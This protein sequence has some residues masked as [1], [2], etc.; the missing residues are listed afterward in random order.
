[1][2]FPLICRGLRARPGRACGAACIL[3]TGTPAAPR[4]HCPG[5]P[6]CGPRCGYPGGQPPFPGDNTRLLVDFMDNTKNLEITGQKA[7]RQF[8]GRSRNS[9]IAKAEVL[10]GG[11]SRDAGETR[12]TGKPGNRHFSCCFPCQA[13]GR[14][15]PG[16]RATGS[17]GPPRPGGAPP[18][19]TRR[20]PIRISPTRPR[21]G[22]DLVIGCPGQ[23]GT[24]RDQPA[25][26]GH[27]PLAS[28][29]LVPPV[30]LA[31][32]VHVSRGACAGSGKTPRK[33][34]LFAGNV[35][36]GHDQSDP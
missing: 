25:A 18:T 6:I 7:L 17:P 30:T 3:V 1:M 2:A 19:H 14:T 26:P 34:A 33:T 15:G 5:E 22:A 28:P 8:S 11:N 4:T 20:G 29:G 16:C 24:T 35:A 12:A 10:P 23:R 13:V 27:W 31:P 36:A 9:L 32:P 21:G